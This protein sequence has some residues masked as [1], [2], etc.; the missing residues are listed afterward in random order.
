VTW[1]L[2]TGGCGFLGRH[3]VTALAARGERVR[4]LDTADPAGLPDEI[5]FI[6]GSVTDPAIVAAALD[7][8]ERLFHLAGSPQLWLPDAKA[9]DR[10]HRQGTE[11]ILDQA[12][13]HRLH[14]IVHCSSEA[15]LIGYPSRGGQ[16]VDETVRLSLDDMTG[17]YARAKFLAEQAALRAAR[18][19]LPVIV[20]NPTALIGPDDPNATPP[21]RM[22][23]MLAEGKVPFYLRCH[24]NLVDVRD[25]AQ[26]H[27]LAAEH[28]RIGEGYILGGTNI[29]MADLV[30]QVARLTGRPRP[31]RALPGCLALAFAHISEWLAD[32]ITGRAPQAPITGVRLAL[33]GVVLDSGKAKREL[34]YTTRPLEETLQNM[35]GHV[36]AHPSP[37]AQ[38]QLVL[39]G[40]AD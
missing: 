32:N 36:T 19:G 16:S 2:V 26:G 10:V 38:Q 14:R 22:I 31:K 4:V 30:G 3:L 17:P 18:S 27:I 9:F 12:A 20:V 34:A 5:D 33:A 23:R 1:S 29:A 28:G 24:L 13:R 7:G 39:G 25:A 35:L 37:L 11:I 6:R 8:V 21:T 15:A 40:G